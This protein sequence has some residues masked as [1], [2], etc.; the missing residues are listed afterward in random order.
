MK[1]SIAV[2]LVI[3]VS[4]SAYAASGDHLAEEPFCVYEP[5]TKQFVSTSVRQ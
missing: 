4:A 1:R 2:L 5:K 3:L